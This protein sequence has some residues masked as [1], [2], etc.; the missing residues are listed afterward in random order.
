MSLRSCG[1]QFLDRS[2][3]TTLSSSD[4]LCFT[5]RREPCLE[6]TFRASDRRAG[7]VAAE[8]SRSGPAPPGR[9]AQGADPR[10][11]GRL[12]CRIWADRAD[13]A[14]R[15]RLRRHAAPAL[16]LLSVESRAARRGLWRGDRGAVQGGVDRAAEEPRAAA[17]TTA[18]RI[19]PRLLSRSAD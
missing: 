5:L 14:A 6:S 9:P 12:L 17:G 11:R 18:V 8:K 3:K 19:L 2:A 16:S 1:L 4:D 15:R 10:A 13:P 7:A